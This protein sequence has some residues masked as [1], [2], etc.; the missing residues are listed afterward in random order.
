MSDRISQSPGF[1]RLA[2]VEQLCREARDHL[3][4]G[5]RSMALTAYLEAWDLL[6][7]PKGSWDASTIILSSVGNL[8]S[9]S[10]DLSDALEILLRVKG[11]TAGIPAS[12]RS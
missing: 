11:R 3:K 6:P 8:L 4:D 2:A 5:D 10:G 1:D 9:S 12:H 7:E